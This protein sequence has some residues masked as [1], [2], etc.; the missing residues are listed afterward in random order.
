MW[1][2]LNSA[3]YRDRLAGAFLGRS[4]GEEKYVGIHIEM[5]YH[6]Y[7]GAD[8]YDQDQHCLR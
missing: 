1:T 5:S 8:E 4:M 7:E 3:V 6:V 2:G